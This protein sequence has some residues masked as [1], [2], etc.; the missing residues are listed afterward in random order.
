[1][2]MSL[3]GNDIVL[4]LYENK[5]RFIEKGIFFFPHFQEMGRNQCLLCVFSCPGQQYPGRF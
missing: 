5:I 2:I 3:K 4:E 1:M